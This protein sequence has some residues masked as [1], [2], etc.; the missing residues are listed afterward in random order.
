VS[1][2]YEGPGWTKA[3]DGKW[4]PPE[5][6]PTSTGGEEPRD[7]AR[8]DS[9]LPTGQ[10]AGALIP[11]A[12]ADSSPA[13]SDHDPLGEAVDGFDGTSSEHVQSVDVAVPSRPEFTDIGDAISELSK[14]IKDRGDEPNDGPRQP[15]AQPHEVAPAPPPPFPGWWE[16]SDGRWY[17]PEQH[18]NL[19]SPPLSVLP[20]TRP[21]AEHEPRSPTEAKT[22]EH[23]LS[24]WDH[25]A[26][27]VQPRCAERP[28]Y[29]DPWF[30]VAASAGLLYL[31]RRRSK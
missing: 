6:A 30:W 5:Q 28:F 27:Q 23:A 18:P 20:P 19:V 4:Y 11:K 29:M 22:A 1:E 12:P 7:K 24:K 31:R 9:L 16:A 8:P 21:R 13:D 26:S 15:E 2:V 17:P 3:S 14:L 10:V 25:D